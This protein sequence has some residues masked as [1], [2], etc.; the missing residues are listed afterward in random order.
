MRRIGHRG[1]KGHAPEN[2]IASFQ[3]AID[4]GCDE[5]ETDVWLL[6]GALVITHDRPSSASGLMTIDEAIDFCR[7]R[8]VLNIEMKSAGS[9]A[10]ARETGAAVA[11]CLVERG[12]KDVYVS[13]FWFSALDGAREVAPQIDRAF[14]FGA[15][16]D[17]PALL[18][19]ARVL[20]LWALHPEHQF[21]TPGRISAAHDADLLLNTWTVN[22]P[23]EIAQLAEWG[24]DGIMSDFPERVPK[25]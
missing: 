4:L 24:V 14:V 21:V 7:G 13:S 17:M 2:T 12:A 6:E 25:R 15:A 5:I 23:D 18:A 3:K 22:D 16:H 11:H 1:A 8:V 9:D 20:D 19:Q 10:R